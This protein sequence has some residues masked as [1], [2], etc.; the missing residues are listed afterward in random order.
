MTM[1]DNVMEDENGSSKI[2]ESH[3]KIVRVYGVGAPKPNLLTGPMT[4]PISKV[5]SLLRQQQ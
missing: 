5:L 4:G 3:G 2:M 1:F